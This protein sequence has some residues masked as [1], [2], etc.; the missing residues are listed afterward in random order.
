[1]RI[2]QQFAAADIEVS[3][4]EYEDRVVL[5]ADF[6]PA[7]DA[8]VDVVGDTVIVV[9]DDEQYE[10]EIG[11]DTDAGVSMHNGIMTVEV[12]A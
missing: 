8:T 9:T 3:R 1:M 2:D 4:R 11:D 5:A 6:G 10:F 12:P 7:A